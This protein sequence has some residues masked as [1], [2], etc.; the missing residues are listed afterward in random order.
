MGTRCNGAAHF[1]TTIHAITFTAT[2]QVSG[3]AGT[4]AVTVKVLEDATNEHLYTVTASAGGEYTATMYDSTRDHYAHV[5]E[6][7]THVGRSA[8]WKAA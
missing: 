4:G 8:K 3:Y 1:L 6:D 5:F 7:A 2:G